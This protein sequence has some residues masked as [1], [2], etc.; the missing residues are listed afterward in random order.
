MTHYTL[1]LDAAAVPNHT[2]SQVFLF[3]SIALVFYF[4]MIRPQQKRQRD[5]KN[6]LTQLKK[7]DALV[8][9]GG[10]HGKVYAVED[11][12]VTL[13]IDS[14]GAKLKISKGAIAT[15]PRQKQ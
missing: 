9:I 15:Q 2:I 5:Q 3:G 14:K 7:G 13:E 1:L 8:T 6:F 4:F 10:I 11:D 12:T